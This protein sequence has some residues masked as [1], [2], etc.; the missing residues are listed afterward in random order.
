MREANLV[1]CKCKR[2]WVI[3]FRWCLSS[4]F[5]LYFSLC[6]AMSTPFMAVRHK[7]LPTSGK[8]PEFSAAF[9]GG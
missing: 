3:M 6:S 4:L 1:A 9:A 7:F 8:F 5:W 2:S